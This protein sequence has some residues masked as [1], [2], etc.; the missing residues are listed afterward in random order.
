VIGLSASQLAAIPQELKE[1]VCNALVNL[2]VARISGTD[3]QGQYV[4][5]RSPRRSIVSGQLLPRF[6]PTGQDDETSDIRIAAAGLDFHLDSGARGRS[7]ITPRF[8]VYIRVLPDWQELQDEA[9]ALDIE[10]KLQ[11]VIQIAIDARI[12]RLRTERFAA[13]GVATPDWP[14]LNPE[15]RSRVRARRAEIQEEV[16]RE[17]YREHGIELERGDEQLLTTEISDES[18]TT[19]VQGDQNEAFEESNS[20]DDRGPQLR[21]DRLI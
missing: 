16:R 2:T 15:Q 21:L 19:A 18:P 4:Y 9:L 11:R 6:D 1:A 13:A 12:R 5:G 10:F 20:V 17:A 8:S 7:T 3:A 14:S